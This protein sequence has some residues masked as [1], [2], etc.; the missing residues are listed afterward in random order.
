MPG[1]AIVAI[2][3]QDDFVWKVSSEKIPHLTLC[4]LGTPPSDF[5]IERVTEYIQHVADTS[6]HTF[7]LSVDRRDKLGPDDTDVLLFRKDRTTRWL[8][9]VRS[10][11]LQDPAIRLAYDS[12]AQFPTWIPHLTLGSPSAPAHPD[13]REWP[14]FSWMCF[15]KLALWTGDFEG[16]EFILKDEGWDQELQMSDLTTM[17]TEF[18]EHFGVKGM[19]WGVRKDKGHEG[20]RAKTRKIARLDQKFARKSQSLHTTLE[21]FN[22]AIPATNAK[23]A[24]ID[25][26]PKYKNA[27]FTRDTPLRRAYYKEGQ[28]AFVDSLEASASSLGTNASGTKRYGVIEKT[29]NSWDVI[30]RDVKHDDTSEVVFSVRPILDEVGHITGFEFIPPKDQPLEHFGVKGMHWG[31]RKSGPK[32]RE[33]T[34]ASGDKATAEKLSKHQK[35]TLTNKELSA[36]IKRKELEQR[37]STLNPSKFK[38]GHNVIK[39]VIS[40]VG[41]VSAAIALSNTP[42]GKAVVAAAKGALKVHK[43]NKAWNAISKIAPLTRD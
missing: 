12:T 37:Y 24:V 27:D 3:R 1:L 43:A 30:L 28:K 32:V 4:F 26:K 29:D 15:D 13:T 5:P 36:V 34:K 39:E 22:G 40:V 42:A 41:T 38:K 11:F 35:K 25:N 31:V 2:P 18:L 10:Y 20:Q 21:I 14:G 19:K 6:M 7:G 17:G 8:E 23:L 9:S 33:R 16:P